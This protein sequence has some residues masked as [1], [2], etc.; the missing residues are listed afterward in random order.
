MLIAGERRYR[1]AVKAGVNELPVIVRCAGADG[2]QEEPD[3]LVE[4]VIENDLRVDLDPLGRARGYRRLLDSGPTIKGIAERLH[5]TQARVK[6]HL[7][8]LKLPAPVQQRV[9]GGEVP[10]RTVKPLEALARIHPGLA[11]AAAGEVLNPSEDVDDE[12]YTWADLERDPLSVATQPAS[13]P[14]ACTGR[15]A[16]RIRLIASLFPRR[17]ARISRRWRS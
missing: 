2:G 17:P 10:L 15:P 6:E 14:K 5:T 11:D 4:A 8:I 1:A 13:C 7:Q 3:L 12:P 16:R 9:G